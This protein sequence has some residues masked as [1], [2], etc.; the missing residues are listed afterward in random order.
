MPHVRTTYTH[1]MNFLKRYFTRRIVRRNAIPFTTWHQITRQIP[2]VKQRTNK[3]KARLRLL[4]TLFLHQK[5]FTGAH[6]LNITLEMKITVASQACLEILYIGLNAFNG[7]VEIIIY[8]TAFVVKR[9]V[10]EPNGVVHAESQGLSG[11]SWLRGPVILSW[12]DVQKDSY[13]LHPGHNIVIHEFAHKL[14]MLTGSFD[15]VP[16]LYPDTHIEEWTKALD[17]AYTTLISQIDHHKHTYINAYAATNPAEF[18]AV[19]CEYFFTSPHTLQKHCPKVYRQ[20]KSYFRQEPVSAVHHLN[21][22][23]K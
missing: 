9:D 23:T 18:F 17:V 15:G 3:E 14:D 12:Q 13:T 7:W 4:T 6:G 2:L 10:R 11:E 21:H 19:M 16:P 22:T 20:L 8:P 1:Y 5:S